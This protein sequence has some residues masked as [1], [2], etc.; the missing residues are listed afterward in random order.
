[1][2]GQG[3]AGRIEVGVQFH[4]PFQRLKRFGGIVSIR[5]NLGKPGPSVGIIGIL[6]QNPSE[7]T[8]RISCAILMK[9]DQPEAIVGT[10]VVG[11]HAKHNLELFDR[12][13]QAC[14]GCLIEL[15]DTKV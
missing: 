2:Q 6:V 8:G 1:M 15:G 11:F 4:G 7:L 13:S 5:V 14:I 10:D 3:I 12:L 9:G